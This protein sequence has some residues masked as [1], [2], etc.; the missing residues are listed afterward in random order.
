MK[1]AYSYLYRIRYTSYLSYFVSEKA[2][3]AFILQIAFTVNAG[4]PGKVKITVFL[5]R[6][7]KISNVYR[8]G[9][10]HDFL[11]KLCHKLFYKLDLSILISNKLQHII[12]RSRFLS[13][14]VTKKFQ[15]M[16]KSFSVAYH[17]NHTTVRGY[18]NWKIQVLHK[19]GKNS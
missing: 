7:S 2:D 11:L 10:I 19:K 5:N 13:L 1:H 17:N 12:L 16:G 18:F 14:S 8:R 4:V 6:K 3:N 15:C 9:K